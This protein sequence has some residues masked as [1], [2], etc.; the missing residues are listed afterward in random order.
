MTGCITRAGVAEWCTLASASAACAIK[1]PRCAFARMVLDGSANAAR[2][3][4]L[5]S[6]RSAHLHFAYIRHVNN[7]HLEVVSLTGT[8]PCGVL[9]A[10]CV[11]CACSRQRHPHAPQPFRLR[12]RNRSTIF[13]FHH[14]QG[15]GVLS[16]EGCMNRQNE[17]RI[18]ERSGSGDAVPL[19]CRPAVVS[20]SISLSLGKLTITRIKL[21]SRASN[22]PLHLRF[23]RQ[24]RPAY[25]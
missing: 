18:C 3:Y 17:S 10:P 12:Q 1:Q 2:M 15:P 25:T 4:R 21:N 6:F 11:A 14:V 9:R 16:I 23:R 13:G 22:Q 20:L 19:A 24:L 7:S 5:T 8:S